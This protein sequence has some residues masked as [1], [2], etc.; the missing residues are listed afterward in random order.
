MNRQKLRR[1]KRYSN[2]ELDKFLKDFYNIAYKDGLEKGISISD[3]TDYTSDL[4]KAIDKTKGIGEKLKLRLLE[5]FRE[6]IDG[7]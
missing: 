5:N 7:N 3:K 2:E 4:I 1:I 6:G